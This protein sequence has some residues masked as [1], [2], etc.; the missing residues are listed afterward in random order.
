MDNPLSSLASALPSLL[1]ALPTAGLGGAADPLSALTGAA[2]PLAGL[3]SQL[4]DESRRGD[5]DDNSRDTEDG[6]ASKD[7][8]DTAPKPVAAAPTDSPPP[9]GETAPP[10]GGEADSSSSAAPAGAET[11]D[12]PPPPTTS[13][14][15]P[16][17]STAIARTPALAQA[18][19]S[20]LGGTP[21]DAAYRDAGITLPPPGTTVTTPIDPSSLTCGAIGMFED[22]YVVAVSSSKALDNG[23][24]VPL[25]SVTGGTGFLGWMDPATSAAPAPAPT[26][27]A[28]TG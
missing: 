5:R 11:P 10:T 22:R 24:V 12:A 14:P 18:V 3:M 7:N 19:T 25:T 4:A 16:D 15:L 26:A 28:A 21:V 13:V 2:A 6:V 17:G 23:E 8:E 9:A 27:P 20:Y 1:G